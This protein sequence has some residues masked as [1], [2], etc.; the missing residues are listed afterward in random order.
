MNRLRNQQWQQQGQRPEPEQPQIDYAAVAQ[1]NPLQAFELAMEH[2]PQVATQLIAR[3]QTDSQRHMTASIIAAEEGNE[4]MAAIEQNR[5]YNAQLMAQQMTEAKIRTE[6]EAQLAP[7]QERRFQEDLHA[8]ARA[9]SAPFGGLD[10]TQAQAVEAYVL[11]NEHI[12]GDW[13]PARMQEGFALAIGRVTGK[14]GPTAATDPKIA[15]LEAQIATLKA[16]RKDAATGGGGGRKAPK[17]SDDPDQAEADRIAGEILG[18]RSGQKS[19][20][21]LLFNL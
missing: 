19:G 4:E 5:A 17:S 7:E 20:M 1:Q 16:N 2:D 11:Q 13:S 12:M 9:A 8:A 18:S 14:F 3:V 15:E 6:Q 10:A 21:G